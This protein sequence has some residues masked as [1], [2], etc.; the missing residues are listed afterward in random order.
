[1]NKKI[2]LISALMLLII[3]ISAASAEDINQT[4]YNLGISDS[5]AISAEERRGKNNH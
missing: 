5:D 4:D 2:L 3:G 1:M